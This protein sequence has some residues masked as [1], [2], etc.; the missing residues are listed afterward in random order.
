MLPVADVLGAG[1]HHFDYRRQRAQ[2][3]IPLRGGLENRRGTDNRAGRGVHRLQR[4]LPRQHYQ[5]GGERGRNVSEGR[6]ELLNS[7]R[8]H[9]HR[10]GGGGDVHLPER[11]VKHLLVHRHGEDGG[12]G[13]NTV[14]RVGAGG[15]AEGGH[16]GDSAIH[17]LSRG[18]QRNRGKGHEPAA[19]G[20]YRGEQPELQAGGRLRHRHGSGLDEL[21]RRAYGVGDVR[22]REVFPASRERGRIL[23]GGAE[24]VEVHV[25]VVPVLR[26]RLDSRGGRAGAVHAQ[27]HLPDFECYQHVAGAVRP[28]GHS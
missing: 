26:L 27:R 21:L 18:R 4:P 25:V 28:G 22:R 5:A 6:D 23:P 14:A 12:Q 9:G 16:A 2:E 11:V 20:R 1:R 24:H 10:R 13:D 8:P 19:G 7:V 17:A 15:V 3:H